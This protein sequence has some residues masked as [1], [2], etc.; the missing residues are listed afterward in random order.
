M[1]SQ[2][3]TALGRIVKPGRLI[4][5]TGVSLFRLKCIDRKSTRLNSSHLVISYAVFCLKKTEEAVAPDLADDVNRADHDA[6]RQH[7]GSHHGPRDHAAGAVHPLLEARV[8]HRVP[9][10]R[11]A[12]LA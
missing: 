8:Q 12:L 10:Y 11:S 7:R 5:L 4:G 2:R 6:L 9:V 1:P 3:R